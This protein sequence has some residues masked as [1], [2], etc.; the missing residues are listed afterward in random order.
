MKFTKVLKRPVHRAFCAVMIGGLMMMLPVGYSYGTAL[1]APGN[2]SAAVRSAEWLK[3]NHMGFAVAAAENF[4]YS[5][6]QPPKGGEVHALSGSPRVAP[7]SGVTSLKQ[8]LPRP[9]DIQPVAFPY[10]PGEGV[11]NPAGQIFHG[12]API[13]E[14]RLHPDPLR[15]S[16]VAGLAWIDTS[17]VSLSLV[18]G[19]Q[20]PVSNLP[21][22]PGMVPMRSRDH[23][24]ATF[25]SG[26]KTQ[27]GHGGFVA[28]GRT[29]VPP[30]KGLG[31]I[32]VYRNGDVKVGTWGGEISPS[33][34]IFYLRQ[35]LPL[36]VDGGKVTTMAKDSSP[37]VQ[38]TVNN[39]VRVYRS[40][41]GIDSNGG[42]VYAAG[43]TITE[44]DLA[45]LLAQAGAV[46]AMALDENSDWPDFF[47][48]A[49][50]GGQSASK[51]LPSMPH[52]T[53]RYLVPDNRDFF[54]VT[55]N[56]G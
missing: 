33:P 17:Q 23:L 40:G 53:Y 16:V 12:K 54:T 1:A 37:W 36:L 18:P 3:N 34:K 13:L 43:N 55:A 20:Q 2:S 15:P 35:N 26:F 39:N 46:R 52:D 11:W 7:A 8:G 56:T 27:D 25:N 50:P 14:A 19:I 22:G 31:T 49:A 6:N 41:I 32:A 44:Q 4:W 45:K 48:Y 10:L 24:L 30:K 5:V 28:H 42:L 51:L 9:K 47:T 21:P 38:N 29:Y